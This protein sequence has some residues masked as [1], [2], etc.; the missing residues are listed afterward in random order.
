MMPKSRIDQIREVLKDRGMSA[1][2]VEGSKPTR[3]CS[4]YKSTHFIFKLNVVKLDTVLTRSF[5]KEQLEEAVSRLSK[6]ME[7]RG[8]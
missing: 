3:V 1:I 6:E 5:T 7:S 2:T 4:A 8:L